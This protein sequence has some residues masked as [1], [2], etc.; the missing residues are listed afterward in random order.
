MLNIEDIL[1]RKREQKNVA[2][3]LLKNA[4][5]VSENRKLY[6]K[7]VEIPYSSVS[8]VL[9]VDRRI[10]KATIDSILQ[11]SRLRKIFTKLDSTPLLRDVAKELGFGAIEIIPT[12]AAEKGIIA[13]ITQIIADTGISVRQIIAEDPMFENAET[14]IITEKPIP[15][16]LIDEILN[17]RGVKKVI[18]L[19]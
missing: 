17:V 6:L 19:N 18:V 4:I 1:S 13:G 7:D 5:R 9:G 14:T 10:V 11:D 8:R 16:E 12:D 2:V 15:R 3:F